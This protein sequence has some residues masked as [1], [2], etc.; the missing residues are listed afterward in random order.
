MYHA[1]INS[2]SNVVLLLWKSGLKKLF[3]VQS[4]IKLFQWA[5]SQTKPPY[6][7]AIKA[8][9]KGSERKIEITVCHEDL[10]KATAIPVV[11]TAIQILEKPVYISGQ[12]FMGEW[13][14]KGSFVGKLEEMGLVIKYK[15]IGS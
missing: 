15:E 6:G 14:V 4:G 10:Y 2:L 3:S 12:F 11:A 7:G 13:V 1:G 5:V 8:T 9:V